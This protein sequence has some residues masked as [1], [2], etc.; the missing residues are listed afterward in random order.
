ME[1]HIKR[2][3]SIFSFCISKL[4]LPSVVHSP[5]LFILEGLLTEMCNCSYPTL[6]NGVSVDKI[7]L[8]S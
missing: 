6:A 2:G 1:N 7:F 8:A 5:S 4:L 3:T